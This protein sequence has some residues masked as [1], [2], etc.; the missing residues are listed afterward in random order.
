MSL[1]F[2]PISMCFV[3][4]YVLNCRTAILL[5]QVI[6]KESCSI[7]SCNL[8]CPLD[9]VRSGASYSAIMI[10]PPSLCLL[11]LLLLLL[12]NEKYVSGNKIKNRPNSKKKGVFKIFLKSLCNTVFIFLIFLRIIKVYPY[13][14]P[15]FVTFIEV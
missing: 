15:L 6:L 14:D 8:G 12:Q 1:P 11:Y 3:F 7:C 2:L 9:K 10:P 4:L 5:A 13:F